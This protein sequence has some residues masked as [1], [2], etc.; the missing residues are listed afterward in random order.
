[1][2]ELKGTI[3]QVEPINSLLS[4]NSQ[5]HRKPDPPLP[6]VKQPLYQYRQK[7][8]KMCVKTCAEVG[9]I[10]MISLALLL[11]NV[12]RC[13]FFFVC[14]LVLEKIKGKVNIK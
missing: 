11:G 8:I 1:M 12:A 5:C 2:S 3:W 6:V 7:S 9:A 10:S 14:L 4:I 13:F